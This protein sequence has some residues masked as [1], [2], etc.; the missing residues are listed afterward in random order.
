MSIEKIQ[1]G[2][3]LDVNKRGTTSV[4]AAAANG[5]VYTYGITAIDPQKGGV[6][7]GDIETQTRRVLDNLQMAL[8]AAGSSLSQAVY[9]TVYLRDIRGD[10]AGFNK[11]YDDYFG[12]NPIPRTV[13]QAVIRSP[14]ARVQIQI[15]ALQ[16]AGKG[17]Q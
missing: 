6:I 14:D 8:Q 12:S 5:L 9:T 3:A 2:N 16:G 17:G 15:V 7:A 4:P 10:Y 1:V 13:V 11:A